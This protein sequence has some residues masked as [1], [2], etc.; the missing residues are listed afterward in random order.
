[1]YTVEVT[2]EFLDYLQYGTLSVEVY[3]HRK[4]GFSTPESMAMAEDERQH[5]SFPE[6][7]VYHKGLLCDFV[8][9]PTLLSIILSLTSTN[10]KL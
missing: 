7:F 9:I 3:G 6:R 4:T 10:A 5:K 1:V 2:D 8:N